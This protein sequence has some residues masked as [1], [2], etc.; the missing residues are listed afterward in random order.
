MP[1]S[2]EARL[3]GALW[4]LFAGDALAAPTHWATV[5]DDAYVF[6]ERLVA[7]LRAETNAPGARSREVETAQLAAA[8]V[9]RLFFVRERA[10][11]GGAGRNVK[12]G[13]R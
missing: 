4:G 6:P 5:P 12:L 1:Q 10:I 9:S 3:R 8:T 13:C 2:V 7:G 11:N